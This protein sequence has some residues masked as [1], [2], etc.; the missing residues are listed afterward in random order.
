MS[1]FDL[2]IFGLRYW[3]Q[4]PDS[5]DNTSIIHGT[6]YKKM[7]N[8]QITIMVYSSV[9]ISPLRSNSIQTP[10]R[11]ETNLDSL[12]SETWSQC[13]ILD[14]FTQR[15]VLHTNCLTYKTPHHT[16]P[17]K[18]DKFINQLTGIIWKVIVHADRYCPQ[19]GRL[20]K[21]ELK[22]HYH[23]VDT[24]KGET[25]W[26]HTQDLKTVDDLATHIC[27]SPPKPCIL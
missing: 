9:Y 21:S 27:S 5:K 11:N 16:T 15:Y 14:K 12:K 25:E 24:Q 3:D 7:R 10:L 19:T 23:Y 6:K 20:L 4:W 2:F 26:F 22:I 17:D 13:H 1:Q 8:T 18:F